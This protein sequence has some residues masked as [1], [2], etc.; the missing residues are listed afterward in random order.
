MP[1]FDSGFK[2]QVDTTF[3]GRGLDYFEP[4]AGSVTNAAIEQGWRFTGF[5]SIERSTEAGILEGIRKTQEILR[6]GRK[7]SAFEKLNYQD[8]S[9]PNAEYLKKKYDIKEFDLKDKNYLNEKYGDTGLK[10]ENDMLDIEA[11][12]LYEKKR[13]EI[14]NNY[15]MSQAEGGR[16]AKGMLIN[17]GMAMLDPV[18]LGLLLIPG[19]IGTK[20]SNMGWKSQAFLGGAKA[21]AIGSAAIEAV[22]YPVAQSEQADYTM[23]DSLINIAF[24]SVASGGLQLGGTGLQRMAAKRLAVKQLKNDE[25]IDVENISSTILE[26]AEGDVKAENVKGLD[27]DELSDEIG[28]LKQAIKTK[29]AR[30]TR[31]KNKEIQDSF[32]REVLGLEPGERITFGELTDAELDAIKKAN[33]GGSTVVRGMQKNKA[34]LDDALAQLEDKTAKLKQAKKFREENPDS[35]DLAEQELQD[36]N[37]RLKKAV[38]A[39]DKDLEEELIKMI[40]SHKKTAAEI[41]K[42][43]ATNK[44]ED[45][46]AK[47]PKDFMDDINAQANKK[48]SNSDSNVP[49][50]DLDSDYKAITRDEE[51]EILEEMLLEKLEGITD[52]KVKA[53]FKEQINEIKQDQLTE[54]NLK[55]LDSEVGKYIECK[56]FVGKT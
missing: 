9:G 47:N 42:Q 29:K 30:D 4:S 7:P 6:S 26:E 37:I 38:K 21:G 5:D 16:F 54:K 20:G 22:I 11:K 23:Y 27:V 24:G 19:A 40:K 41:K 12:I 10:F 32:T 28:Q 25:N 17:M 31:I 34:E 55:D 14:K 33:I 39:G 52:P 48:D 18:N 1:S 15:I 35:L 2:T 13:A 51:L 46:K 45:L 3:Y 49:D 50:K 43:G 56:I 44:R 53:K 8:P 36:L